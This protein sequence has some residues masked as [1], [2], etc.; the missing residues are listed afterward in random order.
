MN[1]TKMYKVLGVLI[2][3][4]W[5][6]QCVCPEARR[7]GE[8]L[9][10]AFNSHGPRPDWQE[11]TWLV[12][13]M[14]YPKLHVSV[15]EITNTNSFGKITT[16]MTFFPVLLPHNYAFFLGW[17]W[18]R[19]SGL[20]MPTVAWKHAHRSF[21]LSVGWKQLRKENQW[22]TSQAACCPVKSDA[23]AHVEGADGDWYGNICLGLGTI[24]GTCW[25]SGY[26]IC[27]NLGWHWH[28]QSCH[29]FLERE[30]GAAV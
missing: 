17:R 2:P 14:C 30:H 10:S 16:R 11:N 26:R 20:P 18:L 22:E 24:V 19:A 28:R 12:I 1:C 9:L 3:K 15:V 7:L 21:L 29:A 5:R 27:L 25:D 23:A 8:K 13:G 4:M 6:P